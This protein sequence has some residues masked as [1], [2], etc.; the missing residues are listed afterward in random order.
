MK[1]NKH[2]FIAGD[3][4]ASN[5]TLDRFPRTGWGQIIGNFFTNDLVVINTAVS[6]RS[7]KNFIEEGHFDNILKQISEGDYLFIQFGHNDQKEDKK[8]HTEPSTSYKSYLTRYIEGVRSIKAVPILL[9]PISRRKFDSKGNIIDTHGDY[10]A[11]MLQLAKE[12]N[13]PIIDMCKKTKTYFQKLGREKTK[14]IFL[15]LEP[16]E[17]LNYPDG[18]EDNVHLSNYGAYQIAKLLIEVIEDL[19]LSIAKYIK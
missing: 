6:G 10:S 2:L 7:S 9:T 17:N 16:G 12:L 5:Y 13:V 19:R 3:S 1:K 18:V 14:E 15:S 4:T 11:A 8:R